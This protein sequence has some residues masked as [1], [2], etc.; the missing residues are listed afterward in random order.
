MRMYRIVLSSV[1]CPAIPYFTK[2]PPSPNGTTFGIKNFILKK[3]TFEFFYNFLFEKIFIL[4]KTERGVY[5]SYSGQI[6]IRLE[7]SGKIF[8]N[9]YK[10]QI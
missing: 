2:T 1:G 10:S 8:E 9:I 6:S 5:G 3:K 4:K 7:F